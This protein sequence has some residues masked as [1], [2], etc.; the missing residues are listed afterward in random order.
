M[1]LSVPSRSFHS[2][3]VT[4]SENLSQTPVVSGLSQPSMVLCPITLFCALL[5]LYNHYNSDYNS[6]MIDLL[7]YF[8][9]ALP[10]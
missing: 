9:S 10:H 1:W 4:F 2:L 3:S 5:W 8:L 6:D 7:S